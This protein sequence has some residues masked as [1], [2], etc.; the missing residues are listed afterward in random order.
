MRRSRP[1]CRVNKAPRLSPSPSAARRSKRFVSLEFSI[2]IGAIRSLLR[3]RAIPRQRNRRSSAESTVTAARSNRPGPSVLPRG[4]A[5]LGAMG[6]S[7]SIAGRPPPRPGKSSGGRKP[8]GQPCLASP[9]GPAG[10]ESAR[11]PVSE[12]APAAMR[13]WEPAAV[14]AA[15]P[16]AVAL[17]VRRSTHVTLTLQADAAVR[18]PPLVPRWRRWRPDCCWRRSP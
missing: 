10:E 7:P 4:S 16:L 8:V 12:S 5:A 15:E 9:A 13:P 3:R 18:G 17:N 6:P 1:S 14:V 2:S 11:P